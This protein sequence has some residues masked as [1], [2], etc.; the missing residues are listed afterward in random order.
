MDDPTPKS[1]SLKDQI[2]EL[3]R[4]R[5]RL[6]RMGASALTDAELLAILIR[7]GSTNLN[8]LDLATRLLAHYGNLHELA[9]ASYEE[10]LALSIPGLGSVKCTELTATLEIA[11]RVLHWRS[12]VQTVRTPEDIGRL[13]LPLVITLDREQFY[14]LP[15]NR[16]NRI[17]GRPIAISIGTADASIA[18]PRDVFRECIRVSAVAVAVA[19]NHPTGDPTPSDADIEITQRLV[20]AG[21]LLRIPLLDHVIIGA[22]DENSPPDASLRIYSFARSSAI[23]FRASAS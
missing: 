15:L 9:K 19:H 17:I 7:T 11:R 6:I 14:A 13:L 20:Q 10:L 18:H 2:P 12:P 21:H 8:V 16:K 22:P 3:D 1:T 23:N 4:P 5:E